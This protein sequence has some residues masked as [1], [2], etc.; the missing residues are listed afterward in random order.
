MNSEKEG[1]SVIP[2]ADFDACVLD[3]PIASLNKVDMTSLSQAYLQASATHRCHAR[4]SFTLF[5]AIAGIHLNPAERGRIWVPGISL[6]GRRSMIPSDIRGE[7]SDVLEA[8][9]PRLEHPGLRARVPT[10]C[11]PTTCARAEWPR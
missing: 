8:I 10:L 7:Q 5:S 9:L 1:P 2:L 11:G 4:K 3:A 6:G